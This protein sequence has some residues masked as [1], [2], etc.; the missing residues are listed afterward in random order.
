M[1]AGVPY[2]I[3]AAFALPGRQIVAVVGDGGLSM[4]LA[5][6]A[7]C[8]RYNLPIKIVV[9]NN[10]ALGQI[11]WEQMMF[12]G[13]PEFACDLEPVN[14]AQVATGLGVTGLRIEQDEQSGPVLDQAFATAGPVLVDAVVDGYEPM[15]PP[16]RRQTYVENLEKALSRGSPEGEHI[17]Q[18]MTQQPAKISLEA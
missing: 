12:L 13:N 16:K 7:T 1:G 14:F 10:A 17:H 6:L 3:A 8:R 4:S 2:A 11:R 5:E 18:A 15:L 9:L